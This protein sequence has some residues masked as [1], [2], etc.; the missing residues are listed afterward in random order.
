MDRIEVGKNVLS[1]RIGGP[2]ATFFVG[3]L[4]EFVTNEMLAQAFSR[5][6]VGKVCN[7]ISAITPNVLSI[8][9]AFRWVLGIFFVFYLLFS[10]IRK[11]TR[12]LP[13][14]FDNSRK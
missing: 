13:T 5:F 14:G 11:I 9:F 10:F 2:V 6:G 3:H 8:K 4:D 12:K 7:K 1:A